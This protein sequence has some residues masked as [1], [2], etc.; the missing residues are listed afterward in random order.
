MVAR[1]EDIAD[2]IFK[3]LAEVVISGRQIVG[4]VLNADQRTDVVHRDDALDA[5]DKDEVRNAL[6]AVGLFLW[7]GDDLLLNIIA[8][9][10]GRDGTEPASRDGLIDI[11]RHLFEIQPHVGDLPEPRDMKA[12]D[13]LRQTAAHIF[14]HSCSSVQTAFSSS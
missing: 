7:P 6:R 13:R 2:E 14:V 10:R 12:S 9:H 5:R 8:D 3:F 4:L 1:A 11:T